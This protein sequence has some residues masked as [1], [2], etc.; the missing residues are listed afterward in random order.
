[1]FFNWCPFL[2][3]IRKTSTKKK[4][5]KKRHPRNMFYSPS[6]SNTMRWLTIVHRGADNEYTGGPGGAGTGF[7]GPGGDLVVINVVVY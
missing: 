5:Q 3:G 2:S 4:S 7:C 1:M 6:P